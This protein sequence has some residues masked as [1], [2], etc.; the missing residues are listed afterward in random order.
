M[1]SIQ[2]NKFLHYTLALL[3]GLVLLTGCLQT[4]T[5]GHTAESDSAH[6]RKIKAGTHYAEDVNSGKIPKDGFIGSPLRTTSETIAGCHIKIR[7]SSPGVRGRQIWGNIVP[8]DKLWVT[9]ANHATAITFD[10]DVLI[11]NRKLAA[12]TYAFFTIPRKKDW[13]VIFNKNAD[14]HG[15]DDYSEKEDVLRF[16]VSPSE[17]PAITQ[18]LT[19]GIKQTDQN[20]AVISMMWEKRT[21]SFVITVTV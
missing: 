14:Q 11:N 12:G 3:A 6:Q 13:V 15:T 8:Y 16:T 7:Y 17:T 19:Y 9:G 10:R 18:R 21:I 20:A 5:T 2:K 1:R 4:H